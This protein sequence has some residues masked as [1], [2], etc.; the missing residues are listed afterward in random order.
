MPQGSVI[1]PLLFAIY[2]AS[3]KPATPSCEYIKYADDLT[4][5]NYVRKKE[6]DTLTLEFQHIEAWCASH[7][8]T[9]NVA[10]TCVLNILSMKSLHL[11]PIP[12][13]TTVKVV[14]LLGIMIREDLSWGTHVASVMNKA[15]KCVFT[16]IQLRR[17]GVA[18]ELL[19]QAYGAF[20]RS[21]LTYAFPSICNLSNGQFSQLRKIER[22]VAKIIGSPSP[23]DLRDF[24]NN[25]CTGLASRVAG[26]TT[27]PLRTL[28]HDRT[29]AATQRSLRST[30]SF[31]PA[32]ARTSRLHNSFIKFLR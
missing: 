6:D 8:M 19:W 3:L 17:C 1:G 7:A 24:C 27:H 14:R 29:E 23:I 9:I 12:G 20:I 2:I 30:R 26:V 4:V 32:T 10:K 18:Q 21:I 5:V 31:A 11:T 13:V 25:I 28:V 15:S 22:R 16:I